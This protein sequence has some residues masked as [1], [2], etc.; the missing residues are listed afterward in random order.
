MKVRY[1]SG[2]RVPLA[3]ISGLHPAMQF[4]CEQVWIVYREVLGRDPVI[5]GAQEDAH[6]DGSLHYGAFPDIRLRALDFD[7]DGITEDQKT[8]IKTKVAA[9]VGN[10]FDIIWETHHLHVEYD[11]KYF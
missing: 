10:Q 7:D 6:D 4:A 3:A 5:T 9:R 1:L 2:R 11:V 8:E